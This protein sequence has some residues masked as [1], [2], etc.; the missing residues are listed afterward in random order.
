MLEKIQDKR[1]AA[2]QATLELI[3][4]QG[5]HGTPM[6]QIAQR[7]NIGVGTIYRYFPSK[8]DLINSLYITIKTYL[9]KFIL[10]EYSEC[11]SIQQK[12]MVLLRN[13]I[14]YYVEHPKEFLF[15]EQYSNSP[16]I[17]FDTRQEGLRMFEQASNLFEQGVEEG[18]LKELPLEMIYM[19]VDGAAMSLVKLCL[20][21]E[22]KPDDKTLN[23]GINAI[24]DGI[25]R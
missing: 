23:A 6:S 21:S 24:W 11:S 4:E 3:A 10:K 2:L 1:A 9:A 25:K 12:F 8:E 15:M 14:D 19:L 20:F 17:T 16:M 5:F 18:L 7:A 22:D 13:L